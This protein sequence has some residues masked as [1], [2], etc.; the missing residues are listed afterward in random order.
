MGEY[1]EY[2]R[3]RKRKPEEVALL[4]NERM[5]SFMVE[6]DESKIGGWKL[7]IFSNKLINSFYK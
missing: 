7:T 3:Q 2:K 4:M 1:K 6:L 5:T